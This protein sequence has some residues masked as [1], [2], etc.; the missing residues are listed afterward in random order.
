MQQINA[1]LEKIVATSIRHLPAAD[2]A[3]SAWPVVCGSAVAE[4]TRAEAFAEGILRVS[5]ADA[6]WKR[7][8]QGLAPR[9]V[10]AI[11]RYVPQKVERIEFSV[12]SSAAAQPP[13][14][15]KRSEGHTR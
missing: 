3:L 6:A 11:N 2:A 5:V 12:R 7:E 9:Y 1:G 14:A 8:L 10:A 4:R 15:Q 13:S